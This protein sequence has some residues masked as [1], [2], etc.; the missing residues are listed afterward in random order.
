MPR[1][2]TALASSAICL[3][4]AGFCA[5]PAAA[6]EAVHVYTNDDLQSMKPFPVSK[7]QIV[8]TT[9]RPP[10]PRLSFAR[11]ARLTGNRNPL[12]PPPAPST[13]TVT[14]KP[15]DTSVTF[16]PRSSPRHYRREPIYYRPLV[17]E[18][19]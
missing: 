15:R 5:S 4:L 10:A 13:D 8:E 14:E 18:F 7:V 1:F 11:W 9:P 6:E 17:V 12:D 16:A 19:P 3:C 2:G